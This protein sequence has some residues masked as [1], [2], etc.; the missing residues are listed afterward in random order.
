[1]DSDELRALIALGT[2]GSYH[3]AAM[4]LGVPRSTLRRRVQQL[5]AQVGMSL[6][7]SSR[8]G[9]SLTGAGLHVVRSGHQVLRQIEAM[10][11]RVRM[12]GE[13]PVGELRFGIPTGLVPE[14]FV[15]IN[16]W[17]RRRFPKLKLRHRLFENPAMVAEGEVDAF[18]DF[19]LMP[20]PPGWLALEILPIEEALFASP[21]Y[22][23]ECGTPTEIDE[24]AGHELLSWQPPDREAHLWPRADGS[25]FEVSLATVVPSPHVLYLAGGQGAGIILVPNVN[26]PGVSAEGFGV[27]QVLPDQ[28]RFARRL[29]F[30]VS[31]ELA[32]LPA[33][34]ELLDAIRSFVDPD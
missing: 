14:A 19:S 8:S 18:L 1:M 29:R 23:A 34:R 11:G 9:V 32:E 5:E 26:L 13:E 25:F 10:L 33:F 4:A 22:L 12:E 21:A 24:L 28:V 17:V 6:V 16:S 15:A 27:V 3:A 20:P 30:K 7:R 2:S 31:E